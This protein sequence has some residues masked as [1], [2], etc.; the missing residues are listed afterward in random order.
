MNQ[1]KRWLILCVLQPLLAIALLAFAVVVPSLSDDQSVAYI[2][3]VL[4]CYA[5]CVLLNRVFLAPR[6]SM[7]ERTEKDF[8]VAIGQLHFLLLR[9]GNASGAYWVWLRKFVDGHIDSCDE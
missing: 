5:F 7:L 8:A 9:R 6:L 3:G 1:D 4:L 2:A